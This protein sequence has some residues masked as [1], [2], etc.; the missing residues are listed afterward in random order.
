MPQHVPSQ[1]P[2]APRPPG[3]WTTSPRCLVP[4]PPARLSLSFRHPTQCPTLTPHTRAQ[5]VTPGAAFWGKPLSCNPG[6][7]DRRPDEEICSPLRWTTQILGG[8][9]ESQLPWAA[10]RDGTAQK[11]TSAPP[12]TRRAQGPAMSP[13]PVAQPPTSAGACP[14]LLCT[15]RWGT[16]SLQPSML[17]SRDTRGAKVPLRPDGPQ[18]SRLA[19]PLPSR[20]GSSP[21]PGPGREAAAN[22]KAFLLCVLSN[23]ALGLSLYRHLQ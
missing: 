15:G 17:P 3:T 9:P 7:G 4:L 20:H 13:G 5:A 19:C 8:P 1:S 14:A 16:A 23:D 11:G 2:R 6:R 12:G 22:S 18:P 21:P 10:L